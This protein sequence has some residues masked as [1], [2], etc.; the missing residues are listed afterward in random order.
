MRV[1]PT[2]LGA[3]KASSSAPICRA[4]YSVLVDPFDSNSS[5]IPRS[6]TQLIVMAVPKT[7]MPKSIAKYAENGSLTLLSHRNYSKG[8]LVLHLCDTMELPHPIDI[9]ERTKPWDTI[10][11]FSRKSCG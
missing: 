3:N 5:T 9:K 10:A 2:S 6:L 4:A 7:T 1:I 11:Q 8:G